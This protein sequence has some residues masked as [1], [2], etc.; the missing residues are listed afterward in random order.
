MSDRDAVLFA[1]EAF[2]AAFN[3]RDYE[4]MDGLWARQSPASCIHPGGGPIFDRDAVMASWE[5]ILGNE[6]QAEILALGPRIRL[7]GDYAAVICFE[8]IAGSNLIAT[9]V[10]VRENRKWMLVHHQSGPTAEDPPRAMR[11]EK[12]PIRFN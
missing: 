10:F 3:G 6:S 9:N 1:N 8:V 7:Y 11:N 4:A 2:Y 5:G 12:G